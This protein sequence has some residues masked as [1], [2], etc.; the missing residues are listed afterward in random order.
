MVHPISSCTNFIYRS[1]PFFHSY[2][3]FPPLPYHISSV[4]ISPLACKILFSTFVSCSS[5]V[6]FFFFHTWRHFTP[7]HDFLCLLCFILHPFSSLLPHGRFYLFPHLSFLVSLHVAFLF[8]SSS[9][10]FMHLH[11]PCRQPRFLILLPLVLHFSRLFLFAFLSPAFVFGIFSRV[12]FLSPSCIS[13]IITAS[14]DFHYLCCFLVRCIS[15]SSHLFSFLRIFRF[16]FFLFGSPLLHH[17]P[18]AS[19]S[20]SSFASSCISFTSSVLYL[21]FYMAFP[22]LF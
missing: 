7:L 6:I 17:Y 11:Q 8:L 2:P 13:S 19:S 9:C 12:L 20:P 21:S 14:S 16:Y 3:C 4:P 22:P 5:C 18:P 1:F 15:L 10:T